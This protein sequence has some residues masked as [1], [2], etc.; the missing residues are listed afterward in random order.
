MIVALSGS[1]ALLGN[2]IHNAADAL[3]AVPLGVAFVI[4]RRATR[5]YTYGYGRAEDLAEAGKALMTSRAWPARR[6]AGVAVRSSAHAAHGRGRGH[7]AHG[8][9][10][11]HRRGG[12]AAAGGGGRHAHVH[13]RAA[14]ADVVVHRHPP[15]PHVGVHR[16]GHVA[17][18]VAVVLRP[19]HVLKTLGVVTENPAS[20]L[21]VP[22]RAHGHLVDGVVP[23]VLEQVV[24]ADL[25]ERGLGPAVAEVL[26]ELVRVQRR[27]L[28]RVRGVQGL[29]AR[30]GLEDDPA[31]TCRRGGAGH[32]RRGV[33]LA[34]RSRQLAGGV[35]APVR[36][37]ERGHQRA[38]RRL[39]LRRGGH[40]HRG[41]GGV[42]TGA[43]QADP[44]AHPRE[45][46]DY[47]RQRCDPAR[48]AV[49]V[50]SPRPA[51][52]RRRSRG[53]TGLPR[54]RDAVFT[55]VGREGP[56]GLT[57]T[58]PARAGR[59]PVAGL[60]VTGLTVAGLAVSGLVRAGLAAPGLPR[61]RRSGG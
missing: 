22:D 47:G 19:D 42:R 9:G 51:R 36:Q 27:D 3:T 5:R 55:A 16:A 61:T 48:P 8:R 54:S 14:D 24:P 50:R 57:R 46:Q 4:G 23:G 44:G 10:R 37:E 58:G 18:E 25:A 35:P 33:L 41:L 56:A 39:G 45:D 32:V 7:A 28:G 12:T 26:L 17:H 38:R 15:V 29:Q 31:D 60:A 20:G 21:V 13:R 53:L 40:L 30:V 43:A 2:T 11:A 6:R 52:R 49:P 34:G 59:R 1:V